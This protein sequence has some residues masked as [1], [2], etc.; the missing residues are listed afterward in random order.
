MSTWYINMLPSDA[1][2]SKMSK[3]S[4]TR[5]H[6][7]VCSWEIIRNSHVNILCPFSAETAIVT[8]ENLDPSHG[9]CSSVIDGKPWC[10]S[11]VWGATQSN[12]LPSVDA[13]GCMVGF[14]CCRQWSRYRVQEHVICKCFITFTWLKNLWLSQLDWVLKM[15]YWSPLHLCYT[16]IRPFLTE[17]AVRKNWGFL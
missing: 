9:D 17:P 12:L 1:W 4:P 10:L 8:V 7:F 11:P 2:S 3:K 6:L 14:V 13:I 16:A 15:H 5:K